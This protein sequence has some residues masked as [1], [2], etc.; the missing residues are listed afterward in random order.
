[1]KGVKERIILGID[2]GTVVMGY[3]LLQIQGN[4]PHFLAMGV[5]ELSKLGDHYLRLKRIFDRIS[6]IVDEFLPDEV[7]IEA[8]F[9]GENAQVMLKLGRAQGV[10]MAAALSRDIPI[11]EYSPRRVKQSIAGSGSASKGQVAEM[12]H[13]ILQI[14]VELRNS[15]EDATDA[16][17]IALCHYYQ[18]SNPLSKGDKVIRS[19]ADFAKNNP[20]R[21]RR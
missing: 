15:K 2:P 4:K 8:P 7:A 19:W 20:E 18:S 12:L 10:A 3:G 6:G 17:A 1:M 21:I 16:L 14:P 11:A 9:L 13:R 5:I